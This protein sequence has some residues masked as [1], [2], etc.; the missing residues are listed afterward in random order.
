MRL[1]SNLLTQS[2][3]WY[4]AWS[5]ALVQSALRHDSTKE[6]EH[7]RPDLD[8][9]EVVLKQGLKRQADNRFDTYKEDEDSALGGPDYNQVLNLSLAPFGPGNQEDLVLLKASK[10]QKTVGNDQA[11]GSRLQPSFQPLDL[12][13]GITHDEMNQPTGLN[14]G[15]TSHTIHPLSFEAQDALPQTG[16]IFEHLQSGLQ[17]GE[18][19]DHIVTEP[20]F[21]DSSSSQVNHSSHDGVYHSISPKDGLQIADDHKDKL[22]PPYDQNNENDSVFDNGHKH[23]NPN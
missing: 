6:F 19:Q 17:L 10:R 7:F 14:Q 5:A 21:T 20:M 3:F 1:H 12:S 9:S 13:L 15:S 4:F 23:P 8:S 18:G 16:W 11:S 22:A 2:A